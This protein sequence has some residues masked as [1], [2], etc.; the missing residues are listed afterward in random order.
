[1]TYLK[2]DRSPS[3]GAEHSETCL[4]QVRLTLPDISLLILTICSRIS[5]MPL[6]LSYDR[7]K[8]GDLNG[9]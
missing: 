9:I 7:G 1:M 5:G 2:S 6:F 4:Y 3:G 8:T